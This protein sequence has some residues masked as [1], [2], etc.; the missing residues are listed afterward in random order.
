MATALFDNAMFD[1]ATTGRV[2]L[3][4][5]ASLANASEI[6]A[7]Y[8]NNYPD[9]TPV[10]YTTIK[11][12]LAQCVASR[13]DLIIVAPGHTETLAAATS[14]ALNV[15]GV[16]IVG[17][18]RGGLR[19]TITY[20]TGNTDNIPVTAA[21]ITVKNI[22][23]VGNF[24][25]IA[26]AFTVTGTALAPDFALINCE[27][28]ETS[29]VL[30]FLSIFTSN[31][32]ANNAD[33]LRIVGCRWYGQAATTPGPLVRMLGTNDRVTITDNFIVRTGSTAVAHIMSSAALVSTNL[34]IARN[35]VFSNVTD[36]SGA[37]GGLLFSTTSTTD[38]GMVHDN[39][40]KAL[41]TA[42]EVMISAPGSLLGEFNNLYD[43]DVDKSGFVSPA[44][45]STA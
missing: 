4:A 9:G 10:V 43:G 37:A 35:M 18:G 15:A 2:F 30:G 29:S 38:T 33:G 28:R 26:S 25:S 42:A 39:Y 22:L 23:F 17:V 36:S 41:D 16:T 21:N 31:S 14:L 11:L 27:F 45:G 7:L 24:L 5:K 1:N 8:G 40:V 19:P 13:G 12:A 44:I 3:V 6:S 32:T 34:E 20:G